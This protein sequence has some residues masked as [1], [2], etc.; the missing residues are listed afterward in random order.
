MLK[1]SREL[2]GH[3]IQF[4]FDD[5]NLKKKLKMLSEKK[6]RSVLRRSV[7]KGASVIRDQAKVNAR[8]FTRYSK[9]DL[10]KNIKMLVKTK[11]LLTAGQVSAD[12]GASGKSWYG[13]LLETGFAIRRKRR[14]PAVAYVPARPWLRPAFDDKY[15]DA[16]KIIKG[17]FEKF[18]R[19]VYR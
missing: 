18:L 19:K 8:K 10:V 4:S 9:G 3:V 15:N 5:K 6:L 14:G 2:A 12:I 16:I 13:R 7:S 11:S 17:Y 1:Y